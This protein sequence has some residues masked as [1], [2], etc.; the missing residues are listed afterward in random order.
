[1]NPVQVFVV[2]CTSLNYCLLQLEN[3]LKALKHV[4]ALVI[5]PY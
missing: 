2:F 1:M 3:M 4:N 5:H